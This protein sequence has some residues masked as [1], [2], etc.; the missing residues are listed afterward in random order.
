MVAFLKS[1]I[2]TLFYKTFSTK[3]SPIKLIFSL[4]N[5][6]EKYVNYT[7]IDKISQSKLPLS[8]TISIQFYIFSSPVF[9]NQ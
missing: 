5:D 1:D 9:L 2:A 4:S 7:I 3:P 6:D 8:L